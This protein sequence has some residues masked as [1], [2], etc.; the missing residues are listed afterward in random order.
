[1]YVPPDYDASKAY[2]LIAFFHGAGERG[3]DNGKHLTD[4]DVLRLIAPDIRPT[5]PALLVAPQCPTG[6]RWVEMDWDEPSGT[7]PEEPSVPMHAMIELLDELEDEFNI[8]QNRLYA[9]GLSMGGFGAWD[10]TIRLPG[11]FAALAAMAG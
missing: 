9:T 10:L 8:D 11:R 4:A 2:P 6:S 1:L 3:T 5:H 7:Q